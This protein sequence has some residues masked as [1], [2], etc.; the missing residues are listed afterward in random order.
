M[1]VYA[2]GFAT[3]DTD[4]GVRLVVHVVN[5]RMPHACD[6][7]RD[8]MMSTLSGRLATRY[9]CHSLMTRRIGSLQATFGRS[10]AP[11]ML[12]PQVFSDH[13]TL[14]RAAAKWLELRLIEQPKSLVCAATGTTPQRTY[15]L[16]AERYQDRPSLFEQLHLLKLDEWG[17]LEMD[18]PASCEQFLRESLVEPLQLQARYKAF[19]SRPSAP[20]DECRR[21]ASWLEQ[22]GPI[23]I[24]VLGLGSNGHVGFNEPAATLQPHAHVAALADTSLKHSMLDR[25]RSRP[26]F[27]LTLGMADLLYAR[28]ILL[29]V[30]GPG[31]LGP[32]KRLLSGTISTEFPASLLVLHPRVELFCD[33]DTLPDR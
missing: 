24:C 10:A 21:V 31:K 22:H 33:H 19:D 5:N 25:A 3:V 11:T 13:E 1:A 14:S 27:G 7:S 15:Q 17:G 32:L 12:K 16:L 26:T 6:E 30:S 18:D 4:C 29:L 23:D 2:I 9:A 28:R 20:E 8:I